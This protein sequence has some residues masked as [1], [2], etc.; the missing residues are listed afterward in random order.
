MSKI[1][2]FSPTLWSNTM[3]HEAEVIADLEVMVGQRNQKTGH[4]Q[5]GEFQKL[6]K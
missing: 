2:T 1:L 5:L 3:Y 4:D 6:N